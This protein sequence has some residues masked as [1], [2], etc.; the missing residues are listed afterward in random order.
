MN[1]NVISIKDMRN[2]LADIID[3]VAVGGETYVVTKFGKKKAILTPVKEEEISRAEKEA[4]L[5]ETA[6]MWKNRADM[7]DPVEWQRK[8]RAKLSSR[9]GKIFS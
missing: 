4:I 7:K 8:T 6:G 2:K 1:Y 3:K 9:Y 5:Q